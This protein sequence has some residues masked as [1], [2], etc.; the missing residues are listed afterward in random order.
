[1]KKIFVLFLF[2]LPSLAFSASSK[3]IATVEGMS[4][5]S[6]ATAI[7]QQIR[8]LPDIDTVKI[9]LSKSQVIIASKRDSSPKIP[10]IQKAIETA[11]YKVKTIISAE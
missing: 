10:D 11:G 4:C 9:S 2:L 1:M 6:C 5:A 3:I 8:K 7:E